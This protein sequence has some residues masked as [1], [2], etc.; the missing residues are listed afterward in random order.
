MLPPA[1]PPS[2]GRLDRA[3][4]IV[5]RKKNALPNK[6]CRKSKCYYM[7]MCAP[8]WTQH[9]TCCIRPFFFLFDGSLF[10]MG[11]SLFGDRA[12]LEII[13]ITIV[14]RRKYPLLVGSAAQRGGPGAAARPHRDFAVAVPQCL[15][16]CGL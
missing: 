8:K 14:N 3:Q 7:S 15:R 4:N 12:R 5:L 10:L 16:S 1:L 6:K 11:E 13:T 9:A 2:R